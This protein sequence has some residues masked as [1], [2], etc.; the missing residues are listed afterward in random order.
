MIRDV[1]K[2]LAYGA[3]PLFRILRWLTMAVV[4]YAF[5]G[6]LV[7][8]LVAKWQLTKI[9]THQLAREVTIEKLAINPFALSIRVR[10]FLM[11]EPSGGEPTVRFDELYLNLS[12]TSLFRLAP[13]L[14]EIRLV[15]PVIRIV[16]NADKSYNYTDLIEKFTANPAPP[17]PPP[18]FSLNN[19]ELVNGRIDFDDRPEGKQH[20]ISEIHIGIPFISSLPYAADINVEPAFSARCERHTFCSQGRDQALQGYA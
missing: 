12:L 15:H 10:G 8:P 18:R 6:F 9:L 17:G 2:A 13:V 16:R 3:T 14:D 20:T 7:A 1:F 5:L 19:I 11:K 4:I